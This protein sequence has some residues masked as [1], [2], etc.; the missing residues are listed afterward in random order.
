MKRIITYVAA[1]TAL[2]LA[3]SCSRESMQDIQTGDGLSLQ[4]MWTEM[5]TRADDSEVNNEY[6]VNSLDWYFY[7]DITAAPAFHYREAI[8]AGDAKALKYVRDF[9]PGTEYGGVAFP[10]RADLCGAD[11]YCTVFVVANLPSDKVQAS[12]TLADLKAIEV[13]QTF[14]DGNS[15]WLPPDVAW[16]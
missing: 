13:D 15:P 8:A 12:A 2:V 16:P 9:V 11:D 1:M 10:H 4:V 3:A 14:L 6:A 5:A 7:K